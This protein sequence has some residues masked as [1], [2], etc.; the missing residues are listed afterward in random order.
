MKILEQFKKI[1]I[2]NIGTGINQYGDID[3]TN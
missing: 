3:E 1:G 2:I